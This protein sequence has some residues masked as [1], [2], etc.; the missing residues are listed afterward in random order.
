MRAWVRDPKRA[1]GLLG[2][3]VEIVAASGEPR[4]MVEMLEGCDAILNVAGEPVAQRW[5]KGVRARLVDSRV[6]LNRRIGDALDA[7]RQA[8]R[9]WLQASAVGYYGD[10][11]DALL[12]ED[13]SAGEGF[14][15]ALC[16]DWEASALAPR[17]RPVRVACLRIGL[18]LAQDGGVLPTMATP[19]RLG[20]GATLGSGRQW[21]P[22][23]H[24]DDLVALF[25][26]AL[27]DDRYVG[28][29]NAVA[30]E[31]VRMR[32]LADAIARQL[33]RPRWL[34]VPGFA[35]RLGLGEASAVVLCGQRVLPRRA[36][37]LGFGFAYAELPAALDDLL[38]DRTAPS[39]TAAA[40]WPASAYLA[41]RTP[42]YCLE[43]RIE[44][45]QPI[46]AVMPFFER[47][48]NLGA[49]TPS[50][51]AFEILGD[52]PASIERGTIIDYRI[53][54]GPIPLR[55]RTRIDRY[56]A[57]GFV[58]TQLRGPYRAWYHEHHFEA[59]GDRTVMVDRVWYA[60]PLGILGAI[61]HRLFIRGQLRAIFS[62]RHHAATLR[63]GD[64]ARVVDAPAPGDRATP[65]RTAS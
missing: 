65:L 55:W 21:V 23:I 45:A 58:D 53:R 47:A 22:W 61:A 15:A 41:D 37:A 24:I 13:A 7:C 56:D 50:H 31:P 4:A 63:F 12:D 28:A 62:H 20:L 1:R 18:V 11:G 43:T 30:P 29:I 14:L 10:R 2:A 59:V 17:A 25:V 8:P 36:A 5:S 19:T 6:A 52:A 64:A 54:L 35:L 49:M 27:H 38:G 9:V 44:L 42:R 57:D 33:R 51:M 32:E 40:D 60:P 39:I 34:R 46:D 48:E 3:E 16:R 26:T